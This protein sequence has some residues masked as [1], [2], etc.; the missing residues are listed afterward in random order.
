MPTP[1]LNPTDAN[2]KND[3]DMRITAANTTVSFPYILDPANPAT[4]ATNGDN[5]RDNIEVIYIDSPNAGE[6]YELQI[7]HKN[8]LY[9]GSQNYSL[10]VTGN[11]P[12]YTYIFNA[13]D[14]AGNYGGTWNDGSNQ[15]SGLGT[16]EFYPAAVV[17]IT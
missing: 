13:A 11:E 5:Y 8:S 2:L 7:T 14:N 15:G 6:I 9:F 12:N 3:L 16:W 17:V 4:A 10:I 1:S